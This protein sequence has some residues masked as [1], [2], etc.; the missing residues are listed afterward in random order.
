MTSRPDFGSDY[1]AEQW[2]KPAPPPTEHVEEERELYGGERE[3][4]EHEEDERELD[5]L[6]TEVNELHA[7]GQVC[8]RCGSVIGVGAMEE[9]RRLPD[10]QWVHEVCPVHPS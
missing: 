4:Y 6:D 2:E 9:A 7:P 1:G 5:Y 3:L 10:G 8:K